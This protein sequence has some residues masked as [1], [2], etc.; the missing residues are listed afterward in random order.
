MIR[1]GQVYESCSGDGRRVR[2]VGAPWGGRV[3]V[4]TMGADGRLL[5]RRSILTAQLHPT[6][7]T[8]DDTPRRTGY[9]LTEDPE[10]P[11]A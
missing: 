7:V 6:A 9:R 2:I 4:A 5:R 1:P 10:A 8:Q 3:D 11:N